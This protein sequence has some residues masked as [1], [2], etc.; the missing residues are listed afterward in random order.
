MNQTDESYVGE[1]MPAWAL[2]LFGSLHAITS[3]NGVFGSVLILT[4]LTRD[5]HFSNASST[6]TVF[7]GNL[8]VTDLYFQLYFFPML[9]LGFSLGRYPIVNDA[10]C[11]VNGYLAMSCYSV[12]LLTLTAISFDRYMRVCHDNLHRKYFSRKT[13]LCACAVIWVAG[14]LTPLPAAL[15]SSLGFDTKTSICVTKP[16]TPPSVSLPYLICFVFSLAASGFFNLRIYTVYRATRRR[17]Q[18]SCHGAPRALQN[19]DGASGGQQPLQPQKSVASSDV[20]L[21][22]S[23]LVIFSCLVL[24]V[25]PGSVAR[26][27]REK[28]DI[29]NVLYA[30]FVW[31]MSLNSS[32]DWIVYGLMNTRF[33]HGYRVFLDSTCRCGLAACV[34]GSAAGTTDT[35]AS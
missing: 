14:C 32:I 16:L 15:S 27:L 23:L 26:G 22:R 34:G 25:T 10:H 4:A 31:L 13:C 24:F 8:V 9:A 1:E 33:R 21:L 7:M 5:K 11:I 28:V 6:Y 3:V 20:A 18:Q 2:A 35:T 19:P 29:P 30:F 17:V 12:F